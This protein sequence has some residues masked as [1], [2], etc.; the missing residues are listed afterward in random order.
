MKDFLIAILSSL[1]ILRISTKGL[2]LI[3]IGLLMLNGGSF[4]VKTT[5]ESDWV[6]IKVPQLES[7]ICWLVV[8]MGV[9][10]SIFSGNATSFIF[11]HTVRTPII[12]IL[13]CM[14]PDKWI[15]RLEQSNE[16]KDFRV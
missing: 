13:K 6:N 10:S 2:P 12:Y 16:T 15:K 1:P 8:W 11:N 7:W 3:I 14:L 4:G 9:D 5:P